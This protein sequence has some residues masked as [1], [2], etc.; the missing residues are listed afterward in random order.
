MKWAF[1]MKLDFYEVFCYAILYYEYIIN[2]YLLLLT[3]KEMYQ[4]IVDQKLLKITHVK[5]N[6]ID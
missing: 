2:F 6:L 3:L 5:R 4:Y 1:V